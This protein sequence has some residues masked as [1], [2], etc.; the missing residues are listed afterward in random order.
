M[1]RTLSILI[2]FLTTL[3]FTQSGQASYYAKRF[4]GRKTASG[5]RYDTGRYTAA[6][7]TLPFGTILWVVNGSGDSCLV[8]VND[9]GPHIKGRIIDVSLVAARHLHMITKGHIK[10]RLREADGYRMD[11]NGTI[12]KEEEDDN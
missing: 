9:R 10:V 4:H 1:I 2:C 11:E 6:H 8:K 3:E 12:V 7:R 5:E